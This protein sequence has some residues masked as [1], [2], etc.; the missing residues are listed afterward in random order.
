M[1][2][3]RHYV[4]GDSRVT[5][6][7]GMDAALHRKHRRL[8]ERR[9]ANQIDDGKPIRKG[10]DKGVA[11][12]PGRVSLTAGVA[13]ARQIADIRHIDQDDA[14]LWKMRYQIR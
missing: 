10:I 4:G 8:V 12:L 7:A 13:T 6:V 3:R 2:Q 1:L 14:R 11:G 9:I 5:E